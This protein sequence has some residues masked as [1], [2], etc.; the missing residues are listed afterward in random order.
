MT[1]IQVQRLFSVE[2]DGQRVRLE[3]SGT[4]QSF[5]RKDNRNCENKA[6]TRP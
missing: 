4:V 6:I 3:G 5:A 2:R 1:L